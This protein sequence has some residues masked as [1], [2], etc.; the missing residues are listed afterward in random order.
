MPKRVKDLQWASLDGTVLLGDIS[1]ARILGAFGLGQFG[2]HHHFLDLI[3]VIF[4]GVC[5]ITCLQVLRLKLE[6]K[7][8]KFMILFSPYIA[9]HS[10]IMPN[11]L[12]Q[13]YS[14]PKR[15]LIIYSAA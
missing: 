4:V 11:K 9:W 5:V 14:H 3:G 15:I 7:I 8:V 10:Q 6:N 2:K 1:W 13:Y 12:D